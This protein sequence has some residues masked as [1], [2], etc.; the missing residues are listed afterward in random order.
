MGEFGWRTS[1]RAAAAGAIALGLSTTGRAADISPE[2]RTLIDAAQKE[3]QLS[4]VFGE[5][6]L[7][8]EAGIRRFETAMRDVWGANLKVTFTPGPALPAM[9][10]QVAVLNAARQPSPTDA[11]VGWSRHMPALYQRKVLLPVD[12]EKLVPGRITPQ[13]HELEGTVLKIVTSLPGAYYNTKLAPMKPQRLADFLDPAWKGKIA[14]TIYAANFD[15][16]AGHDLWGKEKAVDFARKLTTQL[17]GLIR[18]N[19]YERIATGEF[20]ALV[21]NCAARD[22]EEAIRRGAPIANITPRDFLVKNYTYLGVPRNAPHPNAGKLFVA[23]TSTPEGQ[24][25]LRE[26]WGADLDLFP[27]SR[28]AGQVADIERET[29]EKMISA[30]ADWQLKNQ[31]GNS[32]WTEINAILTKS[33]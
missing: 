22:V 31:E 32:G 1:L 21:P 25:I 18:C 2:L 24:A 4:L 17:A 13:L 15:V 20:L 16:L 10:S 14:S 6:S 12:W 27:E 3:G 28:L 30:T 9:A 33:K 11:V 7:G 8:G 5:G 19:E 23:F 29:G 26:N